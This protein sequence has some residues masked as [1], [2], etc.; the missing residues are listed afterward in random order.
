MASRADALIILLVLLATDYA[1]CV[2]HSEGN[3]GYAAPRGS[4]QPIFVVVRRQEPMCSLVLAPP[5]RDA[6]GEELLAEILRDL[7]QTKACLES[8]EIRVI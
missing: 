4:T 5:T 2:P 8:L 3:T 1:A 7:E 6:Q